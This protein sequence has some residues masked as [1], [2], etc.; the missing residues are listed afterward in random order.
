MRTNPADNERRQDNIQSA[1]KVFI[2][3][4]VPVVSMT[5]VFIT[6]FFDNPMGR[7][8]RDDFAMGPISTAHGGGVIGA[9]A[10]LV[11]VAV[12]LGFSVWLWYVMTKGA[13]QRPGGGPSAHG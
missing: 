6:L 11:V 1:T 2:A 5:I 7:R 10:L 3:L 4:L 9:L 13:S 8:I 12:F